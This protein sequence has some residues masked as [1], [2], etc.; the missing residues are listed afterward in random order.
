MLAFNMGKNVPGQE[1]YTRSELIISSSPIEGNSECLKITDECLNIKMS[2][3]AS[4][5]GVLLRNGNGVQTEVHAVNASPTFN[6]KEA[7]SA[8]A[9]CALACFPFHHHSQE[10]LIL[11]ALFAAP[12]S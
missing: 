7:F 4:R 9:P 5:N 3:D 10:L 11:A 6:F 1:S 2:F 12:Y 8:Y